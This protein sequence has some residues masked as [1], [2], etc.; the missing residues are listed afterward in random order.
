MRQT[1]SP[2]QLPP[3]HG[4]AVLIEDPRQ[5]APAAA[6]N[7]EPILR[8]LRDLLPP[9]GLVLELASGSGE[10]VVYFAR[11]LP[12]LSWQPSD[13]NPQARASITA[14][15][16]VAELE[17][18]RAPLDIDVTAS[19][20]P[21]AS[22]Q[23]I[24]CINMLHIAPW[25]AAEGLVAGAARILDSGGGLYLYGPFKR[26]GAHTAHSNALFDRSLRERDPSWGVRDL[27]HVEGLARQHGLH[28]Q[29]VIEMP[30]NN[31]SVWLRRD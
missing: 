11:H 25:S 12:R 6:R 10:H 18:L 31:L 15:G 24:I 14:Y 16:L 9:D 4:I 3:S 27:S 1:E 28:L 26:D 13:P 29:E 17:N 22:A 19:A 20:W 7:R 21:V 2:F 8:A 23:A 5:T 30:A